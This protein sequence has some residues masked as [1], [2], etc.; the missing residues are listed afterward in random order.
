MPIFQ[1]ANG[2]AVK[3][4]I[5]KDLL[6]QA[7]AE[8][9]ETIT[10]LGGRVE[11]KVPRQ[12]YILVQPGTPEEERLRLCWTSPDRPERHFVPYTYVDACKIAGMLLKQIFVENG[13]PIKMHIHP[14]IA[15]VN[16]RNALSHRIM[17]SGGDPTASAQSARVI[18]A[19]PNTEVFQHLVKTYQGVPNKYIESYL[20]VKKCIE[21]GQIVYTPLVYK[22][23]GG[24]RPGEERT[25][26]TEEDEQNLCNWIA[27]KIPYKETG[28]RTGNR[29]Y[30]QLCELSGDP[31]YAWVSRHTWQSWR[32]RY[33][34]NAARLDVLI[35]EIVE[36]KKPVHG[37][38]GQYGY[39]R[40][41][42]EKP[43][44][45]RK[46]KEVELGLQDNYAMVERLI[47]NPSHPLQ[48][49]GSI[50]LHGHEHFQMVAGLHQTS[51]G[52][53]ARAL[54]PGPSDQNRRPILVER[55]E[56]ELDDGEEETEW[57]VRIGNASP[58]EWGK[59]KAAE[60]PDEQP[61]NKKSRNDAIPL[62]QQ[63]PFSTQAIVAIANIHLIES[64]R[65]IANDYRFTV[66][67]VQEFYD[68]C[69]D[70]D[71]TRTRFQK[72]RE[73]LQ[74]NFGHDK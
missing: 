28:G 13:I 72:M 69:G 19:D 20:W 40:M 68:K 8:L 73:L 31:D 49:M 39:V 42:E 70:V 15:N 66:E 5:Q 24:R 50:P 57:A 33:K 14:S 56:E 46:K 44:R 9:C 43:K 55:A 41:A 17:H 62:G 65:G 36:Q 51:N 38:K 4:F 27:A 29:L 7:Q 61:E 71:R 48:G 74:E 11:V 59:R 60:E 3:F 67:E 37:E 10:S 52:L 16:A 18:L 1:D 53:Y 45:Q 32:E 47:E 22:N 34:K 30:Q 54:M 12:G 26:F 21:R 6:Q 58:P 23:P 25:Q 63:A 2:L 35:A 64:I